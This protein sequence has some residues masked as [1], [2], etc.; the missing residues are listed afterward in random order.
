MH[1]LPL[2]ALVLLALVAC[3][4][5]KRTENRTV[6][7]NP[8]AAASSVLKQA[9]E[10]ALEQA[11][12]AASA[13]ASE[14]GGRTDLSTCEQAYIELRSLVAGHPKRRPPAKKNFIGACTALPPN[15]QSCMKLSHS[16]K[17][18]A[19]CKQ[20]FDDLPPEKRD[21]ARILIADE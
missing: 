21:K 20:I 16:M 18:A 9:L 13:A 1:R 10:R 17:N 15:A 4:S 7:P 6:A 19:A 8:A 12:Q 3:D 14:M 5:D 2:T 11:E